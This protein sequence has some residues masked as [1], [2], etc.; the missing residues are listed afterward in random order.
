MG[1]HV[2]GGDQVG[3]A[4]RAGSG[5]RPGPRQKALHHLKPLARAALAVLA[6]GSMPQQGMPACCVLQQV[7]VVRCDLDH[8]TARAQA[9]ALLHGLHIGLG[10]GEPEVEKTS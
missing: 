2:V 8:A 5:R 6:A 7:A 1:Q 10:V 3:L 9:Q 4:A